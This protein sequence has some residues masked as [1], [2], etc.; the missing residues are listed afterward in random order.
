MS[1]VIWGCNKENGNHGVARHSK[2][3]AQP[4]PFSTKFC[5][6]QASDALLLCILYTP[7]IEWKHTLYIGSLEQLRWA[8]KDIVESGN[9]EELTRGTMRTPCELQ[10]QHVAG[11]SEMLL[12]QERHG[13]VDA[14]A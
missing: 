11:E 5:W 3:Q 9:L 7:R 12:E 6:R 4:A 10:E 2:L 8:R 13:N 1:E 14:D